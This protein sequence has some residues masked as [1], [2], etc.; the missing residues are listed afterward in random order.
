MGFFANRRPPVYP[1]A[2]TL[3]QSPDATASGLFSIGQHLRAE[4][5]PLVLHCSAASR[6]DS[7]G[8]SRIFFIAARAYSIHAVCGLMSQNRG[9][10]LAT[11]FQPE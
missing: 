7:N 6:E 10:A 4:I 8:A 5:C 3:R 11:R 1:A 2:A 9:T